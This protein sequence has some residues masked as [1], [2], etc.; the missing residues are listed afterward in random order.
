MCV[1]P[2]AINYTPIKCYYVNSDKYIIN[3]LWL[4]IQRLCILQPPNHKIGGIRKQECNISQDVAIELIH[5]YVDEIILQKCSQAINLL[6][7]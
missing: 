2:T 5:R 3:C 6:A 1:H 7:A 4:S